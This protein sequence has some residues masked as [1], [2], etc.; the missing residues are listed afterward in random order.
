MTRGQ[1]PGP[2]DVWIATR[3]RW[4]GLLASASLLGRRSMTLEL[5]LNESTPHL[6]G[7]PNRV[8]V[9]FRIGESNALAQYSIKKH[10]C[11]DAL[12]G[13]AMNKHRPLIE[14]LHHATERSEIL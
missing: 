12:V 9:A 14:S 3:A 5:L 1:R 11:R 4:L 10:K 7:L 8:Q 2:R 13:G 6:V